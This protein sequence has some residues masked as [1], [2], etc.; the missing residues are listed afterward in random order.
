MSMLFTRLAYASSCLALATLAVMTTAPPAWAQDSGDRSYDG[1]DSRDQ[2]DFRRRGGGRLYQGK[3]LDARAVLGAAE[4]R[5]WGERGEVTQGQRG[6]PNVPGAVAGA[7]IGGILG[8]QIGAGFGKDVATAGGV[9]GGAAVGAN[10]GR[11]ET[12][13][14]RGPDVQRCTDGPRQSRPDYWDVT[15]RFRGIQHRMQ[16]GSEPGRTITVNREGEPR[17]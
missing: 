7:V 13:T 4:R 10:I 11:G 9:L 16:M 17:G 3:V 15:Y 1:H 8:H 5:G 6:G 12:V 14:T 2:R